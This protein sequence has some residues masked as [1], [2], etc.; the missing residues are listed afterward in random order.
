MTR[1]LPLSPLL[2]AAG[3]LLAANGLQGTLIALR[4]DAEG[5]STSTIG[6]ISAAYFLG[7]MSAA[8]LAP[9]LIARVGHIR[10]FAGL[11]A[12]AAVGTLILVLVIDPFVWAPVRTL[13][14]FCFSGLLTTVES[15]IN[16]RT[17][18]SDRG[19][20]LSIY[21]LIDLAGV[22]GG[23]FLLPLFAVQGFAIFAITAILFCLSLVPICLADRSRPKAPAEYRFNIPA[24]WR[25]S[26][27]ACIGCVAIGLTNSAVRLI[28]PL[29]AKE[30]GLDTAGVALFV[31]AGVIGGA[32]LQ[33]PFGWLS[34]RYGRRSS[35]MLAT[36]G[37]VL[38]GLFLSL[39][40]RSPM[41]VYIGAFAFGAFAL[42]LYSLSAAHANDR[43]DDDSYVIVA[44]GLTFFFS[45]GA[46]IGPLVASVVIEHF[47]PPAFFT[48]TS[49]VH[50]SLILITLYRITRRPAVP[51]ESRRP[52][53]S[54]LRTSPA[55]FRLARVVKPKRAKRAKRK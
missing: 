15:W 36:G 18:N 7:F 3:I 47:G 29:Y 54:L 30:I 32:A 39:Y 21:R 31:S 49:L 14:G 46:V 13:M 55:F 12:S 2:I 4:A 51:R 20:V 42:P 38:A 22:T 40:A 52:F 1:L 5:F 44:A 19:R 43:A 27:L 25:L 48:Y 41:E 24:I 26:P 23:Q 11:A 6:F 28:G 17:P 53:V 16:A 33:F 10:V 37:A 45:L 35:I 8:W 9:R 34:D 50:G